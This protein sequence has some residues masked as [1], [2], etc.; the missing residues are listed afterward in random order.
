[1]DKQS[2]NTIKNI[3]AVVV[4]VAIGEG[5]LGWGV[6]WPFLLVLVG[7][8]GVGWLAVGVGVLLSVLNGIAVGLPSLFLVVVVGGLSLLMPVWKGTGWVLAVLSLTAN[9][10]FD[11]LFGF[12]WS[13]LEILPVAG[14]GL[15][16]V[17]W[18]ERSDALRINY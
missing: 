2:K 1:M 9:L 15:L 11:L 18:F 16:A 8:N 4:A 13:W 12:K 10:V 17:A 6:Y 3:L 7:W 5:V 14:A